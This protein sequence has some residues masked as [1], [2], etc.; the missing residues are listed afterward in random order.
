[1][2]SRHLSSVLLSLVVFATLSVVTIQQCQPADC[3]D[4]PVTARFYSE[5]CSGEAT[6]FE[7]STWPYDTCQFLNVAPRS[8]SLNITARGIEE[9]AGDSSTCDTS[10][11]GASFTLNLYSF[12]ICTPLGGGRARDMTKPPPFRSQMILPNVNATYLAPQNLTINLSVPDVDDVLVRDTCAA[13]DSCDRPYSSYDF[14]VSSVDPGCTPVF[15]NAFYNL[16]FDRTCYRQATTGS[17]MAFECGGQNTKIT[18]YF[19]GNGCEHLYRVETQQALC[20]YTSYT[21]NHCRATPL[22]PAPYANPFEPVTPIEPIEPIA[23][24]EPVAPVEPSAAPV[25][26]APAAAGTNLT[27][28]S[29]ILTAVIAAAFL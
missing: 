15:S 19:V 22:A 2:A 18:S 3:G 26:A 27:P 24:I 5:D 20:T 12:Y 11:T 25:T 7:Y 21:V 16:T 13:P 23:P 4:K 9:F 1:M 29:L 8:R 28:A 17:Y 14:W 10:D 6:F